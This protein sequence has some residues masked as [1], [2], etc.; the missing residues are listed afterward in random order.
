[1]ISVGRLKRLLEWLP[2][3]AAINAYEG[4][5]VGFSI[6]MQDGSFTWITA[7]DTEDEDD[8]HY[9]YDTFPEAEQ[10]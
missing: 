5:D 8:Q 7:R 9:F 6:K 4:E 10:Q 3:D 1:M 2:E